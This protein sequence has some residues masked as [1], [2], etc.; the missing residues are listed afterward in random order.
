MAATGHKNVELRLVDFARFE[1]VNEFCDK[2]E[3][4]VPRLDILV[5]NAA[6]LTW[7]FVTTIDGWKQQYASVLFHESW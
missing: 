3:K 4:E 7:K 1:S 6:M 5:A 2:V